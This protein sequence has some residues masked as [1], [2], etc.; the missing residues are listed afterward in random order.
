MLSFPSQDE[1]VPI[2]QA[3]RPNFV[4][5]AALVDQAFA[6][7]VHVVDSLTKYD[8][9]LREDNKNV[10]RCYNSAD[11]IK[12]VDALT[13]ERIFHYQSKI[14]ATKLKTRSNSSEEP[15]T[16][17]SRVT[18]AP[19]VSTGG[20]PAASLVAA[21]RHVFE[22][23]ESS[24]ELAIETSGESLFELRHFLQAVSSH[25]VFSGSAA[26]DESS[27]VGVTS[28]TSIVKHAQA[29]LETLIMNV[30][31]QVTDKKDDNEASLQGLLIAILSVLAS[32]RAAPASADAML[33]NPKVAEAKTAVPNVQEHD[34]LPLQ[35]VLQVGALLSLLPLELCY[36]TGAESG[37]LT[38]DDVMVSDSSENYV[39][40][41]DPALL[42][43]FATTAAV[44]EERSEILKARMLARM[45]APLPA[46]TSEQERCHT[47]PPELVFSALR[48]DDDEDDD[49]E[50]VQH[51]NDGYVT[52]S[53]VVEFITSSGDG[54]LET[55]SVDAGSPDIVASTA[56]RGGVQ[57]EVVPDDQYAASSVG[58]EGNHNMVE[59]V[60]SESD[61]NENGAIS[62]HEEEDGDDE[63]VE[64]DEPYESNSDGVMEEA[65]IGD[66]DV[67]H[68]GQYD[69]DVA[70][71]ESSSSSSSESTDGEGIGDS[72]GEALDT[73]EDDEITLQQALEMSM[74]E[75]EEAITT[76]EATA[77][78]MQGENEI[79]V[80]TDIEVEGDEGNNAP[81]SGDPTHSISVATPALRTSDGQQSTSRTQGEEDDD[82][83]LPPFPKPPASHQ[84]SFRGGSSGPVATTDPDARASSKKSIVPQLDPSELNDFGSI[85]ASHALSHLLRFAETVVEQRLSIDFR[86]NAPPSVVAGGMGSS[87]FASVHQSTEPSITN[88]DSS[89]VTKQGVTLQLLVAS[90]LLL[91]EQ[92]NDAVENLCKA[93]AREQQL[94]QDGDFNTDEVNVAADDDASEAP[95]SGEEDDPALTLAM[96]YVEDDVLL[97][98]DTLENKGMMRKAAAAAYDVAAM[99]KSLRKRTDAW[100]NEVKLYSA[101]LECS[102]KILRQFLQYI[103]RQSFLVETSAAENNGNLSVLDLQQYVPMF[104]AAKL[105]EMLDSFMAINT[106]TSSF[107]V[108]GIEESETERVLLSVSLKREALCLWGEL[109]PLLYPSDVDRSELLKSSI[110]GLS[111][112]ATL[113]KYLPSADL[114]TAVPTFDFEL[115]VHTLKILCRRL[116]IRDLLDAFVSKPFPYLPNDDIEVDENDSK[117]LKADSLLLSGDLHTST[118]LIF[119]L[120]DSINNLMGDRSEVQRLYLALCHRCHTRILLLDGFYATT[121]TESD[122]RPSSS[123]ATK[124]LSTGDT[125]RVATGPSSTLQFDATKCSDSVALL[126]GFGDD[127]SGTTSGTGSVHQRASKVWGTVV[128]THQ[129]SPK[130]GIHRWALRLDKCERGHVFIGVATAQASTKTYVG[131]D[132]FGWGMIGTQALWHDR[133]KVSFC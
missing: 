32:Q 63:E 80:V 4:S 70:G 104:V 61:S 10:T 16:S 62:D 13:K 111:N 79:A 76:E 47:P 120:G 74:A 84:F 1:A 125:V 21:L 121:E 113:N 73:Y 41:L 87:L 14:A 17:P 43:Y 25:A 92:R 28:G 133:R 78:T 116:R 115:Q 67:E 38:G 122:D 105:S 33:G 117:F 112:V 54:S 19:S 130:T 39:R 128:S 22:E 56:I 48:Q 60:G 45:E 3:S 40:S 109:I 27:G 75:H 57:S 42:E 71:N 35:S 69:D 93:I 6:L 36:T 119:L 131:G 24:S 64:D 98:S 68:P 107:A 72:D 99:L 94:A 103:V 106:Q 23:H 127:S 118:R 124:A 26:S 58:E 2:A 50:E 95:L 44:Y 100:K 123:L 126:T 129:Y 66:E 52:N 7:S 31:K 110:E 89:C 96:N 30:V 9:H 102:A 37:R 8:L 101:C 29:N 59:E 108:L 46:P 12:K 20:T 11:S 15:S 34:D 97:S 114:L 49:D 5:K 65:V 90:F 83:N 55:N 82:S 132:K 86:L 81:F 53:N 85:S 18:N 88:V 91:I 51:D 77:N